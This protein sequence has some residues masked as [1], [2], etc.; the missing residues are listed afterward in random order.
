MITVADLIPPLERFVEAARNAE[1]N[2]KLV[3][4]E[5][6]MARACARFFLAQG[7]RVVRELGRGLGERFDQNASLFR[8]Q[9]SIAPSE[10]LAIV[11][12]IQAA[13][14]PDFESIID[15]S[16]AEALRTGAASLF[17]DFPSMTFSFDLLFPRAVAW[18]EGRAAR[19]VTRIDETTRDRLQT[20]ITEALENGWSWTRTASR[21]SGEFEDFAGPPLFPSKKFFSR[22]QAVAAYEIGAAYEAGNRMAAD[23]LAR[24]FPMEKQWLS[25]RD[26]SV[27]PEHRANDAQGWIPLEATFQSGDDGPP[28]DPGCRC[29]LRYRRKRG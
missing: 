4:M 7:E 6:R 24:T 13:M 11:T 2:R 5:K 1:R 14:S 8:V 17:G 19:Q 12:T 25:V 3:P 27:R 22:S 9:E 23:E 26:G 20:I 18:A 10:W 28:T 15:V 21:I 29:A 16:T